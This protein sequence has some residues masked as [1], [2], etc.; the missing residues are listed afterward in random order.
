[1]PGTLGEHHMLTGG[2]QKLSSGVL[3]K[4]LVS[5]AHTYLVSIPVGFAQVDLVSKLADT[6]GLVGAQN[7]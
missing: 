3:V 4:W 7:D 1:M 6:M 5:R 2:D